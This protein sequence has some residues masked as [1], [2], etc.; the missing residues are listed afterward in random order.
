MLIKD[1]DNS[2]VREFKCFSL[3][4]VLFFGEFHKKSLRQKGIHPLECC[5][6]DVLQATSICLFCAFFLNLCSNLMCYSHTILELLWGA[7]THTRTYFSTKKSAHMGLGLL[8]GVL[9]NIS[10]KALWRKQVLTWHLPIPMVSILPLW[11]MSSPQC[12]V[13]E[14]GTRE[15]CAVGSCV[16]V[17]PGSST[18]HLSQPCLST[19]VASP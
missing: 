17:Q 15:R 13:A 8:S 12:E 2:H 16:Q 11:S 3:A 7:H 6:T 14:C 19:A 10:Q 5:K 4:V 18:S 1:N 9:A